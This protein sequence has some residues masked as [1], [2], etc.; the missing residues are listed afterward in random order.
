MC[1]DERAQVINRLVDE[2]ATSERMC[3]YACEV[4]EQRVRRD[5]REWD[6]TDPGRVCIAMATL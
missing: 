6:E 3:L 5:P 4:N 1:R 2:E